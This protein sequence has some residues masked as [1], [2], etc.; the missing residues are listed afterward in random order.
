MARWHPPSATLVPRYLYTALQECCLEHS[1][2]TQPTLPH[3]GP[4]VPWTAQCACGT[5]H[6]ACPWPAPSLRRVQCAALLLMTTCCCRAVQTTPSACS[7]P[8]P[9]IL[10]TA[11]MAAAPVDIQTLPC[12]GGQQGDHRLSTSPSR[13]PYCATTAALSHLCTWRTMRCTAGHGT[14][15]VGLVAVPFRS[16]HSGDFTY[17]DGG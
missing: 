12:E 3:F 13:M 5:W 17:Y 10:P 15:Q 16:P 11:Q 4:Q 14:A 8:T 6:R 1:R 2:A 7:P 9:P